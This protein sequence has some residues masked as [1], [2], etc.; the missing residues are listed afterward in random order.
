MATDAHGP[1]NVVNAINLASNLTLAGASDLTLSG[2]IN[3]TGGLDKTGTNTLTL[4]TVNSFSGGVTISGGRVNVGPSR[5]FHSHLTL[6]HRYGHP[7]RNDS[8]AELARLSEFRT[9]TSGP[10]LQQ[11]A[12]QCRQSGSG[13]QLA[14]DDE[15]PAQRIHAGR[16]CHDEVVGG[17]ADLNFTNGGALNP[18]PVA[19]GFTGGGDREYIFNKA[20]AS[21]AA[22]G[23]PTPIPFEPAVGPRRDSWPG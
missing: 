6:G 21:T 11:R 14:F 3:G 17:K 4:P 13:L 23:F 1:Y 18:D 5:A 12:G 2:A 16:H 8:Y 20:G 15:R 7:D 22:Y 10:V 9:R 19:G